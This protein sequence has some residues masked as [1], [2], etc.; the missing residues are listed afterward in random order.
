MYIPSAYLIESRGLK[1]AVTLG[2][3]LTAA[4]LWLNYA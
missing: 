2:I 4:G 1:A 3:F